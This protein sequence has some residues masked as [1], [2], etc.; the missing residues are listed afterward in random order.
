[1]FCLCPIRLQTAFDLAA[2]L[3]KGRSRPADKAAGEHAV[4]RPERGAYKLIPAGAGIIRAI[5]ALFRPL[6]EMFPS[7]NLSRFAR[8]LSQRSLRRPGTTDTQVLDAG[9]SAHALSTVDEEEDWSD[10]EDAAVRDEGREQGAAGTGVAPVAAGSTGHDGSPGSSGRHS[11]KASRHSRRRASA[12]A[13][14]KKLLLDFPLPPKSI[15]TPHSGSTSRPAE[16]TPIA[17]D[18]SIFYDHDPFRASILGTESQDYVATTKAL[19]TITSSGKESSFYTARSR[20]S[21]G[22]AGSDART[23]GRSSTSSP[24]LPK[25]PTLPPTPPPPAKSRPVTPRPDSSTHAHEQARNTGHRRT[26]SILSHSSTISKSLRRVGSTIKSSVHD[27]KKS[28]FKHKKSA[29]VDALRTPAP[30]APRLELP[31]IVP[32]GFHVELPVFESP[33]QSIYISP[34]A[35][36]PLRRRQ[37]FYGSLEDLPSPD[38]A[39]PAPAVLRAR[40]LSAPSLLSPRSENTP[41]VPNAAFL[42]K[43]SFVPHP[44]RPKRAIPP[45]PPKL[46]PLPH[47][48]PPPFIRYER[49]DPLSLGSSETTDSRIML[50]S[51]VSSA[52]HSPSWLSRNVTG[53]EHALRMPNQEQTTLRSPDRDSTFNYSNSSHESMV[54]SDSFYSNL[55]EASDV[56]SP[57]SV[58]PNTPA[59]SSPQSPSPPPRTV[60]SQRSYISS[61][62]TTSEPFSIRGYLDIQDVRSTRTKLTIDTRVSP[63]PV[64][65]PRR[66]QAP[67]FPQTSRSISSSAKTPI[68]ARPQIQRQRTRSRSNSVTRATITHFRR[69][70]VEHR[71]QSRATLAESRRTDTNSARA[72][73]VP[74][75]RPRNA[76]LTHTSSTTAAPSAAST[77]TYARST[78]TASLPPPSLGP[79]DPAD[80]APSSSASSSTLAHS[81]RPRPRPRPR[82][83]PQEVQTRTRHE[84]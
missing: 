70:I 39:A 69:S 14:L 25:T 28:P 82:P 49:V 84:Y 45:E 42:V 48:E 33:R 78:T 30:S 32:Q 31:D 66:P 41:F 46:S 72:G 22:S 19:S 73:N 63:F 4:D 56:G 10:W 47:W 80:I 52:P 7:Q 64:E 55:V 38:T 59:L 62:T 6:L 29:S 50:P 51:A 67:A 36:T 58:S 11:D 26:A 2:A 15:P 37:S 13:D 61:A 3:A 34:Q 40:Y 60:R 23:V 81:P 16:L 71:K 76:P 18:R 8:R 79:V 1:M 65:R 75:S 5:P 74:T 17:D 57:S 9:A 44:P 83:H 35:Q 27:L 54:S 21:T 24:P 77:T 20:A 12:P 43:P 53:F 68:S